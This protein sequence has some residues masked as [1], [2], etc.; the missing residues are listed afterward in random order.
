MALQEG[1]VE[2]IAQSLANALGNVKLARTPK[3]SLVKFMGPPRKTG[4]LTINEWLEEFDSYSRQLGLENGDKIAAFYDHLG[5]VAKEE[6]LCAPEDERDTFQKIA[7]LLCL[8]FGPSKSVS[9]LTSALYARKQLAEESLAD[10]SRVIMRLHDRME[11]AAV[12]P[13]RAALELMRD[14]VLKE[15]LVNGAR[16][17]AVRRELRRLLVERP[18]LSFF[19]L[20]E[21]LLALLPEYDEP[22]RNKIREV[23]CQEEKQKSST[24]VANKLEDVMSQLVASNKL[25]A[26]KLDLLAQQQAATTNQLAQLTAVLTQKLDTAL[27]QRSSNRSSVICFECKK[28][29]HYA[30]YCR[31]KQ[32]T[33]QQSNKLEPSTQENAQPSL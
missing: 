32:R 6:V 28:P 17:I 16:D 31:S 27:A 19:K 7:S 12:G 15:Q 30:K 29:G 11:Q 22:C 10:F 5:G 4:D 9:S 23:L 2:A 18:E 3:V 21:H 33:E 24:P 25:A 14:R 1:V 8:R 26:D 20:R 13:E